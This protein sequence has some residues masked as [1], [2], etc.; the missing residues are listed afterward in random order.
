[1]VAGRVYVYESVTG[2]RQHDYDL[3][4]EQTGTTTRR[5]ALILTDGVFGRFR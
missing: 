2:Q 5:V 3:D 1:M 4:K